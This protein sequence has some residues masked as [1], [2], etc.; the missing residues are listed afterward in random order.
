M[1]LFQSLL[2]CRKLACVSATTGKPFDE[3]DVRGICEFGESTKA[4]DLTTIGRFGVGFKAVYAVTDRPEVHS[5]PEDFAVENY[6]LPT[7]ASPISRNPDETV[8]LLPF[9]SADG[10]ECNEIAEALADLDA[11]T[12]LFLRKIDQIRWEVEG[13]RRGTITRSSE[14]LGDGVRRVRISGDQMSVVQWLVFSRAVTNDQGEDVG[15]VEIA[16]LLGSDGSIK[17]TN[18]SLLS[19]FFPTSVSTGLKFLLQGPYRTTLAR[20]N[21]PWGDDWNKQ[22][23]RETAALLPEALCWLRDQKSLDYNALRCLPIDKNR[24]PTD[25][26]SR[27]LYE[28]TLRAMKSN[29]LLPVDGAGYFRASEVRLSD[30]QDLRNLLTPEQLG[31]L[32]GLDGPLHWISNGI[33]RTN[34]SLRQ[35]IKNDV[36]VREVIL[37]EMIR[38]LQQR[39]EFLE[40]ASDVFI[41]GLYEFFQAQQVAAN[42]VANPKL[43]L[44]RLENGSHL[45][46]SDKMVKLPGGTATGFPTIRKSV[47]DTDS[48]QR[49][50]KRLGLKEA[51]NVDDVLQ[52]VLP[53]YRDDTAAS[54]NYDDDIAK[55]SAAFNG[56]SFTRKRSLTPDLKTVAFVRSINAENGSK[57]LVRPDAVYLADAER[58]DLFWGVSGVFFMDDEYTCLKDQDVNDVLKSCGATASADVAA[59]VEKHILPKYRS[60]K[61]QFPKDPSSYA[62]DI[63]R[64]IAAYESTSGSRRQ[65][66]VAELKKTNFVYVKALNPGNEKTYWVQPPAVYLCNDLVKQLFEGIEGVRIV[67]PNVTCLQG[68]QISGLLEECGASPNL[69]VGSETTSNAVRELLKTIPQLDPEAQRN[70]SSLLWGDLVRIADNTAHNVLRAKHAFFQMFNAATWVPDANGNLQTPDSVSFDVLHE[71]YGWKRNQ[72]LEGYIRFKP[73]DIAELAKSRGIKPHELKALIEYFGD[74]DVT[75]DEVAQFMAEK[76]ST[77]RTQSPPSD[78]PDP[79]H[80]ANAERDSGEPTSRCADATR[81]RV[82]SNKDD[83]DENTSVSAPKNP[84]Q[85]RQHETAGPYV[86]VLPPTTVEA[87]HEDLEHNLEVE[88]QAIQFILMKEPTWQRMDPNN[89]GYDLFKKSEKIYCEVKS[90]SGKWDDHPAE[91]TRNEFRVALEHGESYWLYVVE[92]VGRAGTRYWKIND[93][94]GKVFRF[95]FNSDWKDLADEVVGG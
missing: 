68:E 32:Y 94:A 61:R 82:P 95:P 20:D 65:K 71:R 37:N 9:K 22:L 28:A 51:D 47:C 87:D 49:F 50:L 42:E 36:G 12:L 64:I 44:L 89:P 83:K 90:K 43:R 80:A 59:M 93:P 39:P 6:V 41:R 74:S 76:K 15:D 81:D 88:D 54:A 92:N 38:K 78:A 19:V 11:S 21:I 69:V 2:D 60:P 33:N 10:A 62:S 27:P 35:Y 29:A 40:N 24:F 14:R 23:V 30:T 77:K 31:Q 17:P 56:A 45:P 66:L 70:R 67:N 57:Q 48:S 25:N 13:D 63:K 73:S 58:K 52:N 75:M 85:E 91:L 16:F 18:Q 7:A 5:G 1:A 55:I 86:S 4:D 26:I 34:N 46:A 72:F 84:G 8:I 79:T 3:I 53:A